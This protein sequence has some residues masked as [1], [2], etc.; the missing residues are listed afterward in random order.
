LE[1]GRRRVGLGVRPEFSLSLVDA[2]GDLI[3]DPPPLPMYG[4][5]FWTD[6]EWENAERVKQAYA[7]VNNWRSSHS[8][9]LNTFQTYLRLRT[10][11]ID[12]NAIVVQR[13]KRLPALIAKLERRKFKLSEV[14]DIGGCRAVVRSVRY[15]NQLVG[16]YENSDLKHERIRKDDY[17]QHPKISGYRGIHIVYSYKSDKKNTWNGLNIEIQ[18][19]ST[20]QHAWAT[21]VETV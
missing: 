3:I 11:Q 15:V 13:I 1:T 4:T 21:A 12:T 17:I 9:P 18:F 8:F 5:R 7:V 16:L 10:H 2:A 14:Q 19:R 6:H 20:L